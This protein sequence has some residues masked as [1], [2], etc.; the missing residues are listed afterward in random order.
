M[1]Y[2]GWAN[3][4][5]PPS[6]VRSI[7]AE[8]VYFFRNTRL[9]VPGASNTSNPRPRNHATASSYDFVLIF[10]A[11][12]SNNPSRITLVRQS[13]NVRSRIECDTGVPRLRCLGG[14]QNFRE[15][16]FPRDSHC[17]T[18]HGQP[19][20]YGEVKRGQESRTIPLLCHV[21]KCFLQKSLVGMIE[22]GGDAM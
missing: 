22:K 16:A 21:R 20:T 5:T 10:L 8:Q 19:A 11:I 1:R 6:S 7:A 4:L 12:F 15:P 18:L 17:R 13:R 14:K 3:T 9:F 2:P